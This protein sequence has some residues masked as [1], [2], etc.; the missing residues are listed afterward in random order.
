[1]AAGRAR[2][3]TVRSSA[4]STR[5]RA[6]WFAA[7]AGISP[8]SAGSNRTNDQRPTTNDER[9]K[10]MRFWKA[11]AYGD[12]FLYVLNR[13]AEGRAFDRLARELCERQTG[14]GADGLIVYEPTPGNAE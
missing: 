2:F 6:R 12:D 9:P 13:D 14:I 10:T 5:S 4:P 11:H 3:T 8:R 1:M 7:S